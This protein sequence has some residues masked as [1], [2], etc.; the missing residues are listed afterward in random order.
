[1]RFYLIFLFVDFVLNDFKQIIC[2]LLYCIWV[3]YYMVK[4][5]TATYNDKNVSGGI[6][7]GTVLA[8]KKKKRTEE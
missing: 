1:M 5:G 2:C 8:V 7:F 3:I 4:V 6:T